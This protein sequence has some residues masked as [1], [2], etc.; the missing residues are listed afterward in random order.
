MLG[1][2]PG[3]A[4]GLSRTRIPSSRLWMSNHLMLKA[5]PSTALRFKDRE[6]SSSSDFRSPFS[7]VKLF[8]T[9]T[10]TK[11]ESISKDD[12]NYGQHRTNSSLINT[13]SEASVF[14]ITGLTSMFSLGVY[15]AA[16]ADPLNSFLTVKYAI[17]AYLSNTAA[18]NFASAQEYNNQAIV[19]SRDTD[20]TFRPVGYAAPVI[21]GGASLF[22][23]LQ[24]SY[25]AAVL[26]VVNSL[27]MFRMYEN[28]LQQNLNSNDHAW[29]ALV[30]QSTMAWIASGGSVFGVD[31][32]I[33]TAGASIL[34]LPALKAKPKDDHH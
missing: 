16:A 19:T 12:S 33:I 10:G 11:D 18:G 27:V 5:H 22:F 1:R 6:D 8:S 17:G 32:W 9:V 21:L 20:H 28:R 7:S 30:S 26:S 2:L 34:Q 24:V 3:L 15:M 13:F 4:R 25:P 23:M 14:Q 29:M 31:P